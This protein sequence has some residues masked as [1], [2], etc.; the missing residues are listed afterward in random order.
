MVGNSVIKQERVLYDNVHGFTSFQLKSYLPNFFCILRILSSPFLFIFVLFE[1]YFLALLFFISNMILDALDGYLARKINVC[2]RL[3]V[4]FDVIGDFSFIISTLIALTI[5]ETYPFWILIIVVCMFLQFFLTFKN[6]APIYDPIGK[7][8][9]TFLMIVLII[10]LFDF[11]GYLINF[12][13]ISFIIF[14]I[15]SI[16]SRI[17]ALKSN[18]SNKVN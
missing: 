5:R 15:L 18:L 13:L 10:T 1:S 7:H 9:G 16:I 3:G 12:I 11:K 14:T 17:F 8:Y 4:Y 6:Q 2:S